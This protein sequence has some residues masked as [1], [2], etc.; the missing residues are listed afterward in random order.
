MDIG[1]EQ[2]SQFEVAGTLSR[3]PLKPL[4]TDREAAHANPLLS[5][6]WAM[7]GRQTISK[8]PVS[9]MDDAASLLQATENE[10]SEADIDLGEVAASI[11]QL[12]EP[13]A[14]VKVNAQSERVGV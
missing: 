5:L 8:S 4:K 9:E 11:C 14:H 3:M 6:L 7:P 10:E 1:T 13:S 2:L 12:V